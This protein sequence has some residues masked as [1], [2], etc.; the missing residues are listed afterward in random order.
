MQSNTP[1][2]PELEI[3]HFRNPHWWSAAILKIS[4]TQYLSRGFG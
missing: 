2:L 3:S 4:N 1:N